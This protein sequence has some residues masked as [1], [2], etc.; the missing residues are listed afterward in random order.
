LVPVL[1]GRAS[2][3]VRTG[4]GFADYVVEALA[5]S[6]LDWTAAAGTFRAEKETFVDIEVTPFVH[7]EDVATARVQAACASGRMRMR[8]T[9]N[10]TPVDLREAGRALAPDAVLESRRADLTLLAGPG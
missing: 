4:R 7:A 2:V 8:A 1:S 9:R 10:D 5:L 3:R 6:G